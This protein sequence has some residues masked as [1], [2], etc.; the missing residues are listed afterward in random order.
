LRPAEVD[1]HAVRQCAFCPYF[2]ADFDHLTGTEAV[3]P[4]DP[5]GAEMVV[6]ELR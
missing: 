6:D 2:E 5:A 1:G 3:W 4:F